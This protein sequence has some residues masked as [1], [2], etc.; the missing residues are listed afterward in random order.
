[1]LSMRNEKQKP[2]KLLNGCVYLVYLYIYSDLIFFTLQI[3]VLM[4]EPYFSTSLLPW[5]SLFFWYCRTAV[6][7]LL[8]PSA[9]ILPRAATLYI[10]AVEFQVN[11]FLDT[12]RIYI[13]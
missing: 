3:S 5:H 9:T 4:G 1:M 13:L 10:V 6:A 11:H 8:H 7:Q 2:L 12:C